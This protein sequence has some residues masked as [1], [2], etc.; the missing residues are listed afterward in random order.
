MARPQTP[1]YIILLHYP[2]GPRYLY[3]K[4]MLVYSWE[5][6]RKFHSTQYARKYLRGVIH[7]Y[8]A[9]KTDIEFLRNFLDIA[10]LILPVYLKAGDILF[11]HNHFTV[12]VEHS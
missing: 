1:I 6:A 4:R 9:V 8:H 7:K 12:L 2:E 10:G 3:N 5:L 11:S